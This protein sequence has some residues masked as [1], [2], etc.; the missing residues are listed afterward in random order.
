MAPMRPPG[1]V[2]RTSSDSIRSASPS[3]ITREREREA[4]ATEPNSRCRRLGGR[5]HEHY[6]LP[7]KKGG[8]GRAVTLRRV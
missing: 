6:S 1:R 4:R 5:T 2:T 8:V 7:V 3:S